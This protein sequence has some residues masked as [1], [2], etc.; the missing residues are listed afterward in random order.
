LAPTVLDQPEIVVAEGSV[1][2]EAGADGATFPIQRTPPQPGRPGAFAAAPTP[3]V[4]PASTHLT[5]QAARAPSPLTEPQAPQSISPYRPSP[6]EHPT[7]PVQQQSPAR[8]TLPPQTQQSPPRQSF[9]PPVSVSGD[10]TDPP[11]PPLTDAE[12]QRRKRIGN[13]AVLAIILVN[14]LVI[15]GL[16]W[17]FGTDRS[18]AEEGGQDFDAAPWFDANWD[19]TETGTLVGDL[20]GAHEGAITSLAAVDT[21]AGSMLFSAGADGA[22]HRWSMDSG[23]R[24][25]NYTIESGVHSMWT[26]NLWG[27]PIVVVVGNDYRPYL[28][29]TATDAFDEAGTPAM[30]AP[31]LV[32]VGNVEGEPVLGLVTDSTY[33]LYFMDQRTSAGVQ[34]LPEGLILPRFFTSEASGFTE[35]ATVNAAQQI[36]VIDGQDGASLGTGDDLALLTA[37]ATVRGLGLVYDDGTPYAMAYSSDRSLVFW[38]LDEMAVSPWT[39]SYGDLDDEFH[40]ELVS[41]AEG[42]SLMY[43]D[44]AGDCYVYSLDSA[45]EQILEDADTGTVTKMENLVFDDGREFAVTGDEY[46]NIQFWSLGL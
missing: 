30:E 4:G 23:T 9:T 10:D 44:S 14:V 40:N 5:P 20:P 37:D 11:E 29:N 13:R 8:Q 36:E 3:V 25:G 33:E 39:A 28:W 31:G 21:D 45:A 1:L 32:R 16:A 15:A 26:T 43:T 42:I 41:S 24:I 38:D 17:H 18:D 34:Q 46:G 6:P 7:G 19:S 35:V 27:E 12:R 2:W 22:I